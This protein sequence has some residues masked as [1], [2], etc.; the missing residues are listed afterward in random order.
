MSSLAAATAEDL[1]GGPRAGGIARHPLLCFSILTLILSWLTIIPYALG[2][3]PVPLLPCGPFLAAIITAA[4]VSGRRGLRSYFRRLI[5]WRTGVGW[6]AVALLAPVAG[7]TVVA[8][9]N[10]LL[11]AAPPDSAQL[12]GWSAILTTTLIFLINPLTG[13]W[14]EP[15]W[16]GYA[17]P[18]LLRR[19]S[20]LVGSAVL[21]VMW[22][23]WHLPMFVVGLIPWWDAAFLF[24]LTFVF[25]S[26][27]LRT[28]GSVPVA[29]LLHAAV[30]GAGGFF[31][32]L[33][34]GDDRVR[35]Y[36]LAAALCAVITLVVMVVSPDR[37][38]RAPAV[39][40]R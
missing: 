6:Y 26:I 16:R 34:T 20:A 36:W 30:N 24:T 15:G 35:M 17:L 7:W 11:G 10:V 29:F 3:F 19:H 4:V 12:T 5:Q 22:T 13:A 1:G 23:L 27:Y 39:R 28:S 8:Y 37:W 21:G 33:F 14:E 38:R 25:T 40:D 9:L 18:L 2:V 32:A 31:I